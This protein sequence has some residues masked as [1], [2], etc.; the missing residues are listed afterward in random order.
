MTLPSAG[1]LVEMVRRAGPESLD[2]FAPAVDQLATTAEIADWLGLSP[3]TIR[4][5][6]HRQRADGRTWPE[7]DK[8]FGR[9]SAWTY[10]TI[11]TYRASMPGSG[12][13]TERAV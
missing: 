7:P 6:Q 8:R 1:T 5:E 12:N 2:A 10:R 9:S 3:Q 4:R 13:R 11:V